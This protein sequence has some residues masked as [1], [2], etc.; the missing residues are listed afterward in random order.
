MEV[1]VA[2][3]KEM[4][5]FM[6]QQNTKQGRRKRKPGQ[7]SGRIFIKEREGPQ[8]L[9]DGH[10]LIVRVC[11]GKLRACDKARGER[12]KKKHNRENQRFR[13]RAWRNLCVIPPSHKTGIPIRV[14]WY[15]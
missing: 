15:R 7:K 9:I 13:G 5:Q 1:M 11:H 14:S 4:P 12:K 3:S 8:Q 10:R 2:A 6:S